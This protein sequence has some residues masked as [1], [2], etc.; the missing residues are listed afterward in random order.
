MNILYV[1]FAIFILILIGIST[2]LI[3]SKL[4]SEQVKKAAS[5]SFQRS[6]AERTLTITTILICVPLF[7]IL[8]LM[9]A[10]LAKFPFYSYILSVRPLMLDLRVNLV[11]IY[12]YSTHPIFKKSAIIVPRH[13]VK[14]TSRSLDRTKAETTLTV[15]TILIIIPLFLA[16]S[17]TISSLLKSPYY[18][19]I[20]SVRPLMLDLRV[21]VVSIY[22]YMTHPVFKGKRLSGSGMFGS[23]TS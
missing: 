9:I 4:R 16:Q 8:G 2:G 12:F 15:T 10:S 23:A 3:V 13:T 14:A 1:V 18:S 6:K 7:L 5:Q 17:L 21:N 11:S 22:F 19:Y 20:L